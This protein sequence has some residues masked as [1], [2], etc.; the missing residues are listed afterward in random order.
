M[1]ERY[2]ADAHRSFGTLKNAQRGR[3]TVSLTAHTEPS[4]IP[5]KLLDDNATFAH[6]R[7]QRDRRRENEREG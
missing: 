3:P 4:I 7:E 2:L 1:Q 6:D 5:H